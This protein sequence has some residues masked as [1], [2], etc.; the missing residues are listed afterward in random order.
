LFP[1][2]GFPI[3]QA[4]HSNNRGWSYET[5]LLPLNILHRDMRYLSR[6]VVN[7]EFDDDALFFNV[8]HKHFLLWRLVFTC[9]F[10]ETPPTAT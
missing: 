7:L 10:C 5:V 6:R 2:T 8:L 1:R 4:M 9:A 3:Q